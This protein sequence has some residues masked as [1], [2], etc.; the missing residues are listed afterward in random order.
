MGRAADIID[1]LCFVA[2]EIQE[3]NSAIDLAVTIV[4]ALYQAAIVEILKR[5]VFY[6]HSIRTGVGVIHPFA[7]KVI[8]PAPERNAMNAASGDRSRKA[9]AVFISDCGRRKDGA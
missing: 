3:S 5:P 2:E 1:F 7:L 6:L 4:E 8:V 9:D